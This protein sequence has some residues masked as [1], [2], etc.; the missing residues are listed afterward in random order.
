M[1]SDL[2][3]TLSML[4]HRENMNQKLFL[5]SRHVWEFEQQSILF[6]ENSEKEREP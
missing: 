5:F 3:S 2:R 4:R 1:D 6:K